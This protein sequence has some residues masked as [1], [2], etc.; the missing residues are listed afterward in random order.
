MKSDFFCYSLW[1]K[2]TFTRRDKEAEDSL[3]KS[4]AKK[5]EK[6]KNN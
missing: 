5:Q 1:V 2:F 4:E 3:V 6:I